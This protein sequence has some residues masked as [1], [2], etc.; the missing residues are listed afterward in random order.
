[1][2]QGAS[3]PRLVF[4]KGNARP[5]RRRLGMLGLVA[6]LALVYGVIVLTSPWATHI[7]NR[8]TPLLYWTGTGTLVTSSGTY[9]M[10]V[11]LAPYEHF[12]ELHMDGLRPTGGV[13]GGGSLCESPGKSVRITL[14]GTI[15]GGWRSTDGALMEFRVLEARSAHEALFGTT[16]KRGY[17]DLF[18]YWH[19][20]Q[21]AMN[22]RSA[23]STAFRS[24]LNPKHASVTF[25]S[26]SSAEF[27]AAC[28]AKT[29]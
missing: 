9:P 17:F 15:Y 27:D 8:P 24:G 20:P 3:D 1:M 16:T 26:G 5:R 21:L 22:D 4:G 28:Q 13:T 19:G 10:Y 14:S 11:W 23:W 6:C 29:R 2:I 25:T 7:G 18:G 12:S